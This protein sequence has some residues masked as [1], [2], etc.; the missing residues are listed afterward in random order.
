M[1]PNRIT[2][3]ALALTALVGCSATNT[4]GNPSAPA[5][6]AAT[7]AAHPQ[8]ANTKPKTNPWYENSW[9]RGE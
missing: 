4:P 2:L 6:A 9:P 1:N 7:P 8:L 5:A 3:A